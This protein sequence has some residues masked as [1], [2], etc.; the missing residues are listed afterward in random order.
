MLEAMTNERKAIRFGVLGIAIL[1]G[2]CVAAVLTPRFEVAIVFGAFV[3]YVAC[4]RLAMVVSH[5]DVLVFESRNPDAEDAAARAALRAGLI[6]GSAGTLFL[7][8]SITAAGSLH[9]SRSAFP[10]PLEG[11]R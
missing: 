11:T 7:G 10:R 4:A 3:G 9:R 1:L 5:A 2:G 8:R 6:A